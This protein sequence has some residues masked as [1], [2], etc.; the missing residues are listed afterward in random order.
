[1]KTLGRTYTP[2][3]TYVVSPQTRCTKQSAQIRTHDVEIFE[4]LNYHD[5]GSCATI[6]LEIRKLNPLEAEE[7]E[8]HFSEPEERAMT[9]SVLTEKH[10]SIDAG[11]K[12]SDDICPKEQ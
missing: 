5:R 11:I 12:V 4:L 6:F 7:T 1:M 3:G 2:I 8:E 10:G 9:F